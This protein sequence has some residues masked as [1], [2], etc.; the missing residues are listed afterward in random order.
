MPPQQ[1]PIKRLLVVNRGEIAIRI[2]QACHEL[3][4]PPTTFALY[5]DTDTTHVTLGRPHHAIKIVSP[6]IYMDINS[7][8]KIAKE[9]S[10][11]AIHPGY[12][13]LSES[14]EFSRRMWEEANVM[15]VGPG[16]EVLERTG[17]KLKAKALAEECGVP[18]LKAMRKPTSSVGEVKGFAQGVGY[19]IMIK[20]VDGGGG[21]GIRLVED[22]SQ[23][24]N[25]VERC[26]G[27]SPSKT[28]FAEQAA[29][30]GFKHIEVQIIGDG[31]GGV[32]H[33]WER[34][35]S[36][37]RR[38]QKIVEVAP[39]PVR[40]R[41]TV[42][43]VIESAMSMS[44]RLQYLGLGTFEYLANVKSGEFFF[45]E[46]NPRIQVEHTISECI[47]GVDLVREQLLIAQGQQEE[48]NHRLGDVSQA[49]DHPQASSIQLRLC[50]EDPSSNFALSIGKVA[51]VVI[52]SGN[53][54]R[55]DSHLSK[56]GSVGADFDNM[57]AKIIV[58][59]PTWEQT[60]AKARRALAET[61]V[62]G[63][64][65][66]I[67]L[68]RAIVADSQ[69]CA[70]EADTKWL[71]NN[72]QTLVSKGQ[73]IGSKIESATAGLPQFLSSAAQTQGL[74]N[75]SVSLRKGDAWTLHL[76]GSDQTGKDA[77]HLSIN[78]LVRNEFPEAMVADI[79]FTAPGQKPLSFKATIA[80]TTSSAGATASTHRRGD[81]NDKNHVV[82]PMSG[83][84]IELLVDE[85]D[86]I[87]EGDIIAFV[88]QMKMELEIRSPRS[89]IVDWVIEIESEE[90]DD[91]A[92][93]VLLV[94]LKSEGRSRPS[95]QS[96]L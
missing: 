24:Q 49:R 11:D 69:F 87:K 29:V 68:L 56:G 44:S 55:V 30:R 61:R 2:L 73:E 39:T 89:G 9:N 38:F 75:A 63:V 32:K 53:G 85:G 90:G 57:M 7:I 26:V 93:G 59:A 46:I 91:V 20:A 16:W 79:S 47:R 58:T 37:Q 82:V 81:A 54:I 48:E 86:E 43:Q 52:P 41:K 28:V 21:R 15:V 50:A 1:R 74:A 71:E 12:G 64:K 42:G 19:P 94:E 25:A 5:T 45:L 6:E 18:V 83:K 14:A 77:H 27:E 51:D 70:G 4:T 40:D 3:P 60:M 95:V 10:I 96:K 76:E 13:F 34:D 80:S 72:M 23:L 62:S 22:E 66:N 65:T 36:V 31:K 67:D 8:I 88:K 78:R 84:L 92:E 17:D 33:L 35:C